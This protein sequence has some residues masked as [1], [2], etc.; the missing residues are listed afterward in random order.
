MI[1]ELL[2]IQ[3]REFEKVRRPTFL[4]KCW[5]CLYRDV[6]NSVDCDIDFAKLTASPLHLQY[7]LNIV[8]STREIPVE[9]DTQTV[10]IKDFLRE[11]TC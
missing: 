7:K 2:D 3:P 4:V 11:K 1:R 10:S 9:L 8:T 5:E 6:G